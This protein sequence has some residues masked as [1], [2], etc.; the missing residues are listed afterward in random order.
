MK[1]ILPFIFITIIILIAFFL[2]RMSKIC[3]GGVVTEKIDKIAPTPIGSVLKENCNCPPPEVIYNVGCTDRIRASGT[4]RV[5]A[6]K[7]EKYNKV[8]KKYEE[9]KT[10]TEFNLEK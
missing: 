7:V 4:V 6:D 1:K 9:V 5:D 8:T 2:G 3:M 10:L